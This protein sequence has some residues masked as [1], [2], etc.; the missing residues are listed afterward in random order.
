MSNERFTVYLVKNGEV[1]EEKKLD[2]LSEVMKYRDSL[3]K[4]HIRA[5]LMIYDRMLN[6][7]EMHAIRRANRREKKEE[8]ERL[9]RFDR[10]YKKK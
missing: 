9:K 10:L 8:E 6:T 5:R 7:F 4:S 2:E 1:F 3:Q